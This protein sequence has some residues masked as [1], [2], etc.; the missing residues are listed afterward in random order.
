LNSF[1][2]ITATTDKT[3]KSNSESQ[4]LLQFQDELLSF[5]L[6]N[7]KA[8]SQLALQSN[9]T[10]SLFTEKSIYLVSRDR[11][12]INQINLPLVII[13][14]PGSKIRTFQSNVAYE[15]RGVIQVFQ[16]A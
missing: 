2:F 11:R 12:V 7:K 6:S 4:V 13:E 10:Y 1:Y 15:G 9:M 5:P 3:N 14:K 8:R 16:K